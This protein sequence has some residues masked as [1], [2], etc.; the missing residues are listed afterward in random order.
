MKGIDRGFSV[1]AQMEV[2]N[3]TEVAFVAYCLVCDHVGVAG[4]LLN[5]DCSN[6]K[7]LMAAFSA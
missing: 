3:L 1:N 2:D 7:L 4:G 5:I 6:K